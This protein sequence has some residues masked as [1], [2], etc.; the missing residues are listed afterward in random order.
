MIFCRNVTIYFR[1]ESTRR[2]VQNFY[3]AL[4]PGGYLFIGHS[5]TL[6]S[7]SD[8]FEAV[9]VGGVFLY[10]KPHA[11]RHVSFGDIVSRRLAGKTAGRTVGTR[12]ATRSAASRPTPRGAAA[13]PSPRQPSPPPSAPEP[14]LAA[15]QPDKGTAAAEIGQLIARAHALLEQAQ[16]SDALALARQAIDIDPANTEAHLVAAFAHADLGQLDDAMAQAQLV[17]SS[18]PLTAGARYILG[19]I[20]QQRGDMDAALVEYKR[21]VYIDRDFV[22]AHF[23]IANIYRARGQTSDA[24][25]EYE[26]TLRAL[27]AKPDGQWTAFL[28]GFRP[29]LLTTTCERSLIECGRGV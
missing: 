29:D 18:F 13:S 16:A 27:Y 5:E 1:L 7:I 6:T 22:L 17:L 20:N 21:T 9:E 2:V 25:R 10:R 4:N 28:G 26:N 15:E 12:P 23:A 14:A 19:I 11:R 3:D 8:Q 24:C